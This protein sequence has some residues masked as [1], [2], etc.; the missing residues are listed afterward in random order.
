MA[1]LRPTNPSWSQ[2]APPR[3]ATPVPVYAEDFSLLVRAPRR[4]RIKRGKIR[5]LS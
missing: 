5:V 2:A 3:P 1:L 4:L